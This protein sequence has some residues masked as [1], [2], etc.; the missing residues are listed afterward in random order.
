MGG[1]VIKF[2]QKRSYKRQRQLEYLEAE[3]ELK[4]GNTQNFLKFCGLMCIL[5][6]LVTVIMIVTVKASTLTPHIM[7]WLGY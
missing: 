4:K 1:K 5:A 7:K 2:P 6:F 3:K